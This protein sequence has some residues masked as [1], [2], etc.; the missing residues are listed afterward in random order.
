[1]QKQGP[2]V[3]ARIAAPLSA[4]LNDPSVSEHSPHALQEASDFLP[5]QTMKDH[6]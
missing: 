6:L 5:D 4:L 2:G 3:T 1:M